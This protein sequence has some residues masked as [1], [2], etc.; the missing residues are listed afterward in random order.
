[1]SCDLVILN[2]PASTETVPEW[3]DPPFACWWSLTSST[4]EGAVCEWNLCTAC[5]LF[6]PFK[7]PSSNWGSYS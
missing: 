3:P 1:M 5:G 7:Y 4:A 2:I 6:K